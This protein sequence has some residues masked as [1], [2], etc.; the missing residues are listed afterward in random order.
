[1]NNL[2][3]QKS[4]HIFILSIVFIFSF[5]FFE[6]TPLAAGF[7]Q[8]QAGFLGLVLL[9]LVIH[10]GKIIHKGTVNRIILYYLLLI[11]II[12]FYSAY[13]AEVEFGQPFLYGFLSARGWLLFGV[14]I[15]LYHILVTKKM[16]LATIE[17]TFVFMAWSSL[18]IFSLFILT[19]DPSQLKSS[20]ELSM[21]VM[22]TEDRGLRFKF[23][24]YFIT[25]GAL[26]YFIKYSTKRNYI[27]L[28]FMILFLA[29]IVFVI[30]GRTYMM[31]IAAVF[32]LYL[33]FNNS[34][35]KFT[36]TI[37]KVL[38][39]V[40]IALIAIQLIMPNYL[41]KMG[42]LF[43]QMFQVLTGVTSHDNSANARIF[44]SKYVYD[45]FTKHPI[46]I[47]LGTGSISNQWNNGYFSIF[48]YFY[49]D[50]IGLLG[51]L[52]VHG[53]IGVVFL[54]FIPS[55]LVIKTYKR[56]INRSNILILTLKYMLLIS[57]IKAI[58]GSFYFNFIDYIVPLFILLA[59]LK[60]QRQLN[61]RQ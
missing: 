58:L 57:L 46:S 33:W 35:N 53:I 27:D 48:G 28:F 52:F 8:L 20:N 34:V 38:L 31:T 13:R 37:I 55:L 59:Y 44:E 32:L 6:S 9:F 56:V 30:Q 14:G 41:E 21:F 40:I 4:I 7:F 12:P 29:Y 5:K 3:L 61:A 18:I 49:P 10:V 36:L 19:F 24:S 51:G 50:D 16:T 39:F 22:N 60:L 42:H 25:F 45:Y 26:Y 47:W 54:F 1:M 17:S 15:W 2:S 11:V 23:Q 43:A